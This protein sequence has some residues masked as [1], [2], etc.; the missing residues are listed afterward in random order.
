MP[1]DNSGYIASEAID[2]N[3]LTNGLSK[4]IYDIGNNR[5]IRKQELDDQFTEMDKQFRQAKVPANQTL[6][7]LFLNI[8]D[9]GVNRAYELNKA[10]KRGEVSETEYRRIMN[11]MN[12][13]F[14]GTIN[15]VATLDTKIAD[16]VK[17]QGP[18]GDGSN[19][20]VDLAKITGSLMELQGKTGAI[21]ADGFIK[22]GKVDPETGEIVDMYDPEVLNKPENV[23]ADKYKLRD[24]VAKTVKQWQP[25]EEWTSTYRNGWI[26]IDSIKNKPEY[27]EGLET[28][29]KSL[30]SKSNQRNL[31]SI[32]SDNAGVPLT[33]YQTE[34]EK[35]KK[36]QSQIDQLIAT[37]KS[38][39]TWNE[40]TGLTEKE[41][42]DINNNM[43]KLVRDSNNVFQPEMTEEQYEKAVE[44]TKREIELQVETNMK[45]E[46]PTV[47]AP[48]RPSGDGNGPKYDYEENDYD[49]YKK[50]KDLWFNPNIAKS[51]DSLTSLTRGEY[52]FKPNYP[53]DDKTGERLKDKN[54]DFLKQTEPGFRVYTKEGGFAGV[55]ST[56]FDLGDYLYEGK[57]T[58]ERRNK[59]E[60]AAQLYKDREEGKPVGL[61]NRI[62]PNKYTF[63]ESLE[64]ISKKRGIKISN[65][66]F[67]NLRA[68]RKLPENKKYTDKQLFDAY[69]K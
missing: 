1:L 19:F 57:S 28:L 66:D 27:K 13:S 60:N 30:A 63:K 45:G 8:T 34:E 22:I 7:N 5:A 68:A 58:A 43:V 33:T 2:W 31:Y 53:V 3:G 16:M 36:I 37:K 24:N 47:W 21:D 6:G 56:L 23:R 12:D 61:K 17:R 59:I 14:K 20:E 40:K 35:N 10:L 32:L 51:A 64:Y 55:A 54:G 42:S 65:E 26:S 11:N 46:A 25:L 67:E 49:I 52:V 38:A 50:A 41:I 15:S 48:Q 29:A 9:A 4:T 39:G 18:D 62:E 44:F 69:Y